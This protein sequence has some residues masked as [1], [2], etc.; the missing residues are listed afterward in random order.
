MKTKVIVATAIVA[1]IATGATAESMTYD[2]HGF[3]EIALSSGVDAEITIGP[4]FS[5]VAEARNDDVLDKLVVEVHGHTLYVDRRES[6]M[7]FLF[8][9]HDNVRL[10]ITLPDLNELGANAGVNAYVTGDYGDVF[11]ADAS[12]GADIELDNVSSRNVELS[13]SSGANIEATGSC[14]ELDVSVSS[15]ADV[16]AGALECEIVE[17]SSSS[18]SQAN[19]FAS[20]SIDASASSGGDVNIWG[21]PQQIELSESSGGDTRIR[22]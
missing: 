5:V 10:N 22:H 7:S 16:D 6:V 15:G 3:D 2:L 4:D 12:S 21:D 13:A 9:S 1:L 14:V 18:G 11:I 20:E 19:V 8:G 17:A